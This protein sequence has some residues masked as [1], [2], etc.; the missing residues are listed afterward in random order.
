MMNTDQDAQRSTLQNPH[1]FLKFL[2]LLSPKWARSEGSPVGRGK[3]QALPVKER[4]PKDRMGQG[5]LS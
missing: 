2:F 5:H 1:Q 4:K 3:L